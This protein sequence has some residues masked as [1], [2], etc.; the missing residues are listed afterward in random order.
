MTLCIE[1]K[2]EDFESPRIRKTKRDRKFKVAHVEQEIN[3]TPTKNQKQLINK[4]IANDLVFCEA[5]AGTGKTSA[6]LFHFCREYKNDKTKKIVIFRTPVEAGEDRIGF[7]PNGLD[8][9]LEPHFA[10]TRAI[11]EGFL[12]KEKVESDIGKR[13]FF[14]IPNY[15]LGSTF[16]DTFICVDES[17]MMAP[18]TLKLILERVGV[19]SK[20]VVLGDSSQLY[21]RDKKRNALKDALG[22]FFEFDG[23][24]KAKYSGV[25]YHRFDVEDVQRSGLVKSVIKAYEGIS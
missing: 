21:S 2:Y 9:K 20:V 3:F 1:E 25:E 10:S 19:N 7:L 12:G 4:I 13:I 23:A 5:V 22:R 24:H 8:D 18:H 15:V 16:D 14:N 6:S 11:L 17:Q